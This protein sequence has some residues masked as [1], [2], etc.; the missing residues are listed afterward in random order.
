MNPTEDG[1]MEMRTNNGRLL[2]R[3]HPRKNIIE[4]KKGD[5]IHVVDLDDGTVT[6][7][8]AEP[9]KYRRHRL[10]NLGLLAY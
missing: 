3:F 1:W 2:F 8:P 6:E 9:R 5:V 4:Q 7:R 10:Q